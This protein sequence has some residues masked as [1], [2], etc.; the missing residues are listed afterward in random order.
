M[1]PE[2]LA[3]GSAV[4]DFMNPDRIVI[5][6][7]NES[8]T[9][10]MQNLYSHFEEVEIINTSL[11]TA[12]MIKYASNSFLASVISYSNEIANLCSSIK[13]IDV[14]DVMNGVSKDRRLS[15]IVDGERITPGLMSFLYPGTGFGG[16][17][18]PKD[19]KALSSFSNKKNYEMSIL[20]AVIKVNNNQPLVTMNLLKD[21]LGSLKDKKITVLGLAFKPETDD[22]RESPAITILNELINSGANILAHDPIASK[23]MSELF[24]N[25]NIKFF[26]NLE[27]V[28]RNETDAFILVTSWQEY[29][30]LHNFINPK[31]SLIID[32]RRFLDKNIY[33]NYKGIG[34]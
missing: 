8:T 16:S 19:I 13:N 26:D 20:D 21:S 18:F 2:F 11:S 14:V 12:E 3:E 22:I 4:K 9:K 23:N 34:L 31:S 1:N 17:C 28:C 10:M 32:G 25:K 29:K 6:S 33:S 5:G 7:N 15:P 27:E 30:N 24:M